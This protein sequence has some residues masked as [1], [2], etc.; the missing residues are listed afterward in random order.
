MR[1]HG[2]QALAICTLLLLSQP[3]A[4]FQ[5]RA[6]AANA[7]ASDCSAEAIQKAA[8]AHVAPR[9]I[10]CRAR[11]IA[12]PLLRYFR[13]VPTLRDSGGRSEAGIITAQTPAAGEPLRAGG[14]LALSVSTGLPDRLKESASAST[15]TASQASSSVASSQPTKPEV[16]PEVVSDG[17]PLTPEARQDASSAAVSE[18]PVVMAPEMP[19]SAEAVSVSAEPETP[20]LTQTVREIPLWVLILAIGVAILAALSFGLR[21]PKRIASHGLV[22][23]VTCRLKF[24]PGRLSVKGRLVSGERQIP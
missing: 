5:T 8:S 9:L 4:A 23:N 12:A 17:P 1:G 10:D 19:V 22:P 7:P 16:T 3:A 14:S 24:G 6:D 18:T 11:D 15:D 13:I 2:Y 21:R 20:F